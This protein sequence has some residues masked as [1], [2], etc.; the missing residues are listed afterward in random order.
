MQIVHPGDSF[1]AYKYK[2]WQ[3]GNP[4]VHF[5]HIGLFATMPSKRT[6][7]SSILWFIFIPCRGKIKTVRTCINI[8][9]Y[10]NNPMTVAIFR[11]HNDL[12]VPW[13]RAGVDMNGSLSRS[14]DIIEEDCAREFSG[15]ASAVV[16]GVGC[17]RGTEL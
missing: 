14:K 8:H 2:T 5:T 1:S 6:I 16:G 17:L 10:K 15:S 13:S 4:E 3:A 7:C 9:I 12:L 11:F